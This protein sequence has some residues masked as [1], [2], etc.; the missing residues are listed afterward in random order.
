MNKDFDKSIEYYSKPYRTFSEYLKQ[1]KELKLLNNNNTLGRA[2]IKFNYESS[3]WDNYKLDNKTP[4]HKKM[5]N[6]YENYLHIRTSVFIDVDSYNKH[7]NK[8]NEGLIMSYNY[9]VIFDKFISETG[10]S[11]AFI[12]FLDNKKAETKEISII[13]YLDEYN[14]LKDNINKFIF[15]CGYFISLIKKDEKEN[16]IWLQI[17]PKYI[18]ELTSEDRSKDLI[19]DKENNDIKNK[20]NGILY[21]MTLGKYYDKIKNNGLIPKAK[22]KRST[23]PERIYF[24]QSNKLPFINNLYFKDQAEL[25]YKHNGKYINSVKPFLKDGKLEIVILKIDLYK[26]QSFRYR[27]FQDPNHIQGIFTYEPIHPVCVDLYTSFY[28]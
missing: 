20:C 14:E 15:K 12:D 3:D 19:Y 26:Y 6:L 27:F 17:E 22:N 10:V 24:Y 9:N 13:L 21:H 2:H 23:H 1:Y 28:I 25:F 7:I 4:E 11:D 5:I 16:T 18:V 8:L